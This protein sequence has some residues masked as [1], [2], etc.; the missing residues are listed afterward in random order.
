MARCVNIACRMSVAIAGVLLVF[1]LA[2][3]SGNASSVTSKDD[4]EDYSWDELMVISGQIAGAADEAEA[5]QVAERFHLAKSDGTL[6]EFQ[7]KTVRLTDGAEVAVSII[8][9]DHDDRTDGG[10]AG[11]TFAFKDA[12]TRMAMADDAGFTDLSEDGVGIYGGWQTSDVRMW[13]NGE[14][15]SML[16]PDLRAAIVSVDKCASS[17]DLESI[18]SD[19]QGSA[20]TAA[21]S[22][23][24]TSSDKLWLLAY[25]EI[26]PAVRNAE[27]MTDEQLQWVDVLNDEGTVYQRFR[28]AGVEPEVKNS[29]LA[30]RY[31]GKAC[32]WWLRSVE[33]YSFLNVSSDGALDAMQDLALAS[34]QL[35]VVPCFCI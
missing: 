11:I 32:S 27:D 10:K 13:L 20:I 21:S 7:E 31:G 35:G 19:A 15:E 6:D 9:F 23:I 34:E 33:S 29:C 5:I 30:M 18:E 12:V 4:L 1:A 16:P 2:G 8:G 24:S 17:V 25:S 28:E 3:C 22:C 26:T 14:F